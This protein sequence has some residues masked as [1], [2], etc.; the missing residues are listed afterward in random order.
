MPPK[1]VWE[2]VEAYG[3]IHMDPE[4][5]HGSW[6]EAKLDSACRLNELISEGELEE[7]LRSTKKMASSPADKML[8]R[9][10]GWGALEQERRRACC[11][12]SMCDYL[13]FGDFSE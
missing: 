1:T 11:E 3:A 6:E 9:S 2:W 8:F 7:I 10:D 13:D 12:D 5:A 4:K